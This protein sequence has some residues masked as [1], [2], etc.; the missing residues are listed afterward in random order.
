MQKIY[1]K[2]RYK[3]LISHDQNWQMARDKHLF[4]DVQVLSSDLDSY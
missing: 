4:Q 3:D 2:L 1:K